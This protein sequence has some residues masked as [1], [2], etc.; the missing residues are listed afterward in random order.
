MNVGVMK[1]Y[2]KEIYAP[3]TQ[4]LDSFLIFFYQNQFI[5]LFFIADI[6]PLEN[7]RT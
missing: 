1:D 2:K 6:F 7:M 3:L 5:F 4:R